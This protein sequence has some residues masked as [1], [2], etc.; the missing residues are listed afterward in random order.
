MEETVSV[1]IHVNG[2]EAP[3][4]F[5]LLSVSTQTQINGP[6]KAVITYQIDLGELVDNTNA[7]TRFFKSGLPVTIGIGSRGQTSPV[8]SGLITQQYISVS[9]ENQTIEIICEEYSCILE[10]IP[11]PANINNLSFVSSISPLL[12]KNGFKIHIASRIKNVVA[13]PE[14][15]GNLF[16]LILSTAKLNGLNVML[17]DKLLTL[18][19]ADYIQE[20]VISLTMGVNII[21]MQAERLIHLAANQRAADKA[22]ESG[23]LTCRGIFHIQGSSLAVP[24]KLTEINEAGEAFS[25]KAYIVRTNHS[26][27]NGN[28][29]T[30]VTTGL[31]F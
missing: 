31:G 2:K 5:A 10:S 27:Q 1:Q 19:P 15:S 4:T 21:T 9:P 29:L 25:G 8:F 16:D 24:G 23:I 20:P 18:A 14:S 3:E 17:K 11:V 13:H 12:R 26:V 7:I 6:G 22:Q 30:I 28:W